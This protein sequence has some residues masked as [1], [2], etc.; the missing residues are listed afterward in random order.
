MALDKVKTE[1]TVDVACRA[2]V[3]D[4]PKVSKAMPSMTA[5]GSKQMKATTSKKTAHSEVVKKKAS[6]AIAKWIIA[7]GIAIQKPAVLCICW[8]TTRIA[9]PIVT[10]RPAFTAGQPISA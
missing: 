1:S 7:K 4:E 9:Y 8:Q 2:N 10:E 3:S 5:S 6:K